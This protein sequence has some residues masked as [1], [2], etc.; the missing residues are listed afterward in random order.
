VN[1]QREWYAALAVWILLSAVSPACGQEEKRDTFSEKPRTEHPRLLHSIR[2]T[3]VAGAS[4]DVSYATFWKSRNNF[5]ETDPTAKP[6]ANLPIPAFVN[7]SAT[8]LAIGHFASV[9]MEHNRHP[10]I[11]RAAWIISLA[12]SIVNSVAFTHSVVAYIGAPT[13]RL[14]QARGTLARERSEMV[15]L[16]T[17]LHLGNKINLGFRANHFGIALLNSP[18]FK[19]L[20]I[21]VW[22][23]YV[24]YSSVNTNGFRLFFA[25]KQSQLYLPFLVI[26]GKGIQH[27]DV[28]TKVEAE[29]HA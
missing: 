20:V 4:P 27:S 25:V 26:D 21:K 6:G 28:W 15:Q 3:A 14:P 19:R 22:R 7:C 12:S 18:R 5:V 29:C 23:Q 2:W 8:F 16:F 13:T 17:S 24:Y 11:R 1:V 10:V 9:K